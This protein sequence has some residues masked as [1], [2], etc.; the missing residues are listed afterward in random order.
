M[1]LQKQEKV[2]IDHSTDCYGKNFG[3]MNWLKLLGNIRQSIDSDFAQLFNRVK[4][5]LANG[6]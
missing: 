1:Y 3:Y 6:Q 2:Y 5:R 4:E